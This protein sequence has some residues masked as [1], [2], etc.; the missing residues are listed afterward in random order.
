MTNIIITHEK[1]QIPAY[2][3]GKEN[4]RAGIILI[5]EVWGLN[6][7]IRSLTDRLA[8]QGYIVLAPDLISQTGITEKIDQSILAEAANPAT[9]DEAQKKMRAAM[10]PIRS[11]EFGKE[12]IERLRICFNYLRQEYGLEK[13]GVMGFCFGG[14]YAYSLAASEP[15]LAAVLPF[16]GHAPE[17]EEE[18]SRISCP[19]MA[20]YG[21]KDIALVQDLPRLQMSMKKLKKDF[22]FKVYPDTGHAFMNDTNPTTYNKEAADDAWR[23]ALKF[24]KAHL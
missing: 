17:K 20:F 24:L 4:N 11:E 19:V 5:H 8:A 14:T 9:R 6:K 23:E 12:T 13:I 16:Y 15:D 21:E 22:R 18:L 1:Y 3:A 2:V 7:N 10:T